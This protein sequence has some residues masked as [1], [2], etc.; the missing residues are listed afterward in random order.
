MVHA[1]AG[2]RR[3]PASNVITDV[4]EHGRIGPTPKVSGD[5][6]ESGKFD[7]NEQIPT[8]KQLYGDGGGFV[9]SSNHPWSV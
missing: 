2:I 1:T 6:G 8:F 3:Y 5:Y 7:A 9:N 4:S